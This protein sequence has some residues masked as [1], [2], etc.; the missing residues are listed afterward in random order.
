MDSLREELAAKKAELEMARLEQ[1][2]PAELAKEMAQLESKIR[3]QDLERA[4]AGNERQHQQ[5][6][7]Q[8]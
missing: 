5:V 7:A 2:R 3:Q 1:A 6:I 8:G 4:R